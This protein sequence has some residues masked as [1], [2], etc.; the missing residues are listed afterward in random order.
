MSDQDKC[1]LWNGKEPSYYVTGHAPQA[2]PAKAEQPRNEPVQ[3][4]P[5]NYNVWQC[6][7]YV[8]ND[9]ALPRGFDAPPRAAAEKALQD[10]GIE[11]EACFS[12]WGFKSVENEVAVIENRLPLYT[13]PQAQPMSDEQI[14]REFNLSPLHRWNLEQTFAAGARYAER[15]HKIGG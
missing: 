13:S 5:S 12:G 14:H 3:Q 7:I 10:A 6:R 1:H 2:A 9:V 11:Y 8:R 15:F 4:E